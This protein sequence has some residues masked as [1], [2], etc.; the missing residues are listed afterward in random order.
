MKKFNRII[1]VLIAFVVIFSSIS[2]NGIAFGVEED[3]S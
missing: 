1:S 2:F 3:R